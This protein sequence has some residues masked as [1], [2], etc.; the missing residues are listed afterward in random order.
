MFHYIDP[1]KVVGHFILIN[2]VELEMLLV[3]CHKFGITDF[4]YC[5][6]DLL[7]AWCIFV[8]SENSFHSIRYYAISQ[9]LHVEDA[10]V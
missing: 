7:S 10:H 3:F 9:Q 4:H 8:Y 6:F 5:F 2:T 1:Q